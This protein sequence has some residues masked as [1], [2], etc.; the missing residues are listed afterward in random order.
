M[1]LYVL[2]NKILLFAKKTRPF[3]IKKWLVYAS[4]VAEFLV[5]IL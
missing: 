5:V 4:K 2:L 3:L 1:Q